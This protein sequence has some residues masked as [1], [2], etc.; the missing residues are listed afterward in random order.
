MKQKQGPEQMLTRPMPSLLWSTCS[1]TVM[2]V[3]VYSLYSLADTFFVARGVG[4][5]AAGAVSLAGPLLTIIGAFASMVGAGGSSLVSRALGRDDREEAARIIANTFLLFYTVTAIFTVL[6][7]WQ[8]DRIVILLGADAALAEDT[9]TYAGIIIAGTMTA[10][11]FSSLMRAEGNIRQSI[12]QWTI[13]SL[14]N[15]IFD[16]I[17][18]F[19]LDLGVAGAAYATVLSQVV[20]MLLSW[21]YFLLS[22]KSACSIRR[23]HFRPDLHLMG[24]IL[25][26]GLPSLLSQIC[27]SGYMTFVN[28][29]LTSL[30]GAVAISAFGIIGR[31]KSFLLIPLSGISQ[32]LQPIF[33]FNFAAEKKERVRQA[34]LISSGFTICY[35]LAL[36]LLCQ[37]VPSWLLSIFISEDDVIRQGTQMLRVI[38]LTLPLTGIGSIAAVYYQATGQK[39]TAYFLPIASNLLI[40]LPI[41]FV[42][43]RLKGLNGA[44]A[45][46]PVSDT[47]AF[48]LNGGLLLRSLRNVHKE[49]SERSA[50]IP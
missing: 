40:S 27:S 29:Q 10:T 2:S 21:W 35:G 36:L 39:K 1:Q 41:L 25:A 19:W 14:V 43:A 16:P 32:G 46:F 24:E 49:G 12:Y 26:I 38:S 50:D 5:F 11:G 48:L 44:I 15:L 45:S 4:A 13:P 37:I 9:A 8:L 30:G 3:M 23:K 31:L 42:L 20:S 33:G 34:V 18:I 47:L 28:R 17:F 22:G 6:G 7:L